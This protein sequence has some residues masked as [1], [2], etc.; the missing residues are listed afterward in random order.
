MTT[1]W[2]RESS[3]APSGLSAEPDFLA[4]RTDRAR[5]HRLGAGVGT[6]GSRR[7]V[8]T[9]TAV[10]QARS[11]GLHGGGNASRAEAALVPSKDATR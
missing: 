9:P 3:I 11:V 5:R 6:R 8:D 4:R 1:I 7:G 2:P 10:A